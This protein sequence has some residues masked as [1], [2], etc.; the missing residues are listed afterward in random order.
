MIT[1][2]VDAMGGDYAPGEVI[3]GAIEG[4]KIHKVRI[5]LV[6]RAEA[7]RSELAKCDTQGISI[8]VV[9]ASEVVEMGESASALRK[10]RD[11]SIIVASKCV[12]DG[13]AQGLVAA[14]STGAAMASALLY[15]GRIEGVERPAIAVVMPSSAKS[16]C[17][18]L[19]A[20]ANADCTPEMLAQFSVMGHV[21]MHNIFNV[22]KPRV[23]L[24]NIGEEPGKG[25][26]LALQAFESLTQDVRFHFKGNIEGRD[27]FLGGA[28]VA[29]TD[30]FSGNIALKSAEGVMKMFGNVLKK[31]FG[32]NIRTKTGY[33]LAR[34]AINNAV[35][36]VDP[37]EFGGALLLGIK[38]VCVI[39]HG[40]SRARGIKNAIRVAKNAVATNLL[41]KICYQIQEGV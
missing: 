3:A 23:G 25:N 27:I 6:G 21:F 18:L 36:Y 39:S 24:L 30:G 40:G 29:V 8:D 1:I 11:A 26:A 17:L 14:G 9:E 5:L 32:K 31:E 35:K 2:A 4:A 33:V 20:G 15:I 12:K 41:D 10:K 16:P 37:E 22:E 28:D 19:D 7:V 34:S 38:G 13:R